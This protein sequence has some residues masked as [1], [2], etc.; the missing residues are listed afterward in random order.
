MLPIGN[1][2]D[3]R[4]PYIREI[5]SSSPF[6]HNDYQIFFADIIPPDAATIEE[7][8]DVFYP[9]LAF[10]L[11]QENGD[12]LLEFQYY[13]EM[14]DTYYTAEVS[15]VWNQ[16]LEELANRQDMT[17]A[18]KGILDEEVANIERQPELWEDRYLPKLQQF[19]KQVDNLPEEDPNYPYKSTVVGTPPTT[20]TPG[21]EGVINRFRRRMQKKVKILSPSQQK[22]SAKVDSQ[23]VIK[24]EI[25][26]ADYVDEPENNK[27]ASGDDQ[28]AKLR[29]LIQMKKDGF[30]TEEEFQ[31][32]KKK[33]LGL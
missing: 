1:L 6:L 14:R 30:M 33:I 31:A 2:K 22:P 19:V 13:H 29:E 24:G 7:L 27:Q 32:A 26:V 8:E 5:N 10:E 21:K 28:M 17:G 18:L 4:T 9:C 25:V 3:M 15:P 23:E 20:E 12:G 11:I 16:A